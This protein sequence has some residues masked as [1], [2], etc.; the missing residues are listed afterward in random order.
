MIRID[1]IVRR[2]RRLGVSLHDLCRSAD[3]PYPTVCRWRSPNPSNPLM[4]LFNEVTGKLEADL[5][6]RETALLTHLIELH[7]EFARAVLS[8]KGD[9]TPGAVME[10][11][12]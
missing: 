4:R 6:A 8:P 9:G 11:A 2:A 7:P 10:A 3:V 5:S 1:A 12:E